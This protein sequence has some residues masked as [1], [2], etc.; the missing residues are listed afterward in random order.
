MKISIHQEFDSNEILL[1]QSLI[2]CKIESFLFNENERKEGNRE[3]YI[4]SPA[5]ITLFLNDGTYVQFK[6]IHLYIMPE[7]ETQQLCASRIIKSSQDM[8]NEI[9]INFKIKK[10]EIYSKPVKEILDYLYAREIFNKYISKC[11]D[12][13]HL[14][15][16]T[17]QMLILNNENG[18]RICIEANQYNGS[19][20]FLSLSDDLVYKKVN[21]IYPPSSNHDYV[22]KMCFELQYSIT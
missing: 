13:F 16:K 14:D 3:I 21:S 22:N 9:P 17:C 7:L 2:N 20:I 19:S 12:P 18:D 10:I 1:L 15:S 6:I 8:S 5:S 11:E 4:F